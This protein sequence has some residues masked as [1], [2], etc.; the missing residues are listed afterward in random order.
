MT[1]DVPNVNM[2]NIFLFH[3]GV[4]ISI[5]YHFVKG[6]TSVQEVAILWKDGPIEIVGTFTDAL[7]SLQ[8]VL[9]SVKNTIDNEVDVYDSSK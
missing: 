1:S 3:K 9:E 2:N 7:C 4:K 8:D 5:A 6:R